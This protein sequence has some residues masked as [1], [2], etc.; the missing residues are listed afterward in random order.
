MPPPRGTAM[1]CLALLAAGLADPPKL[2][3]HGIPLPAG[4]IARLGSSHLGGAARGFDLTPDGKTVVTVGGFWWAD[5]DAVRLWDAATGTLQ[6]SLSHRSAMAVVVSVDGTRAAVQGVGDTSC[7]DVKAG[8]RLWTYPPMPNAG[9][10]TSAVAVSPDGKLVVVG[11]DNLTLLD[12]ATGETV[13]TITRRQRSNIVVAVSF[14]PDGTLVAAEDQYELR[15]WAAATGQ[16]VRTMDGPAT[17]GGLAFTP[18]G[19]HLL[20]AVWD[21]KTAGVPVWEIA[22]GKR[23]RTLAGHAVSAAA[24][25]VSPDGRLAATCGGPSPFTAD[26]S[27]GPDHDTHIYDLATGERRHVLPGLHTAAAGLRFT[28]DSKTLLTGDGAV[29]FWDV[30]TRQQLRRQEGHEETVADLRFDGD[31]L[32]TAGIDGT[33]RGWNP[34]TGEQKWVKP[35]GTTQPVDVSLSPDGRRVCVTWPRGPLVVASEVA[36]GAELGRVVEN[37]YPPPLFTPA[38]DGLLA[39]GAKQ[40]TRHPFGGKPTAVPYPAGLEWPG[41][42]GPDG[43]TA[44]KVVSVATKEQADEYN[45][46]SAIRDGPAP[47]YAVA[48]W[49]LNTGKETGRLPLGE[50]GTRF[51]RPVWSPDGRQIAVSGRVV[52]VW[53]LPT[54]QK[55]AEVLN[56]P[57]LAGPIWSPDGKLLAFTQGEFLMPWDVAASRPAGAKYSLGTARSYK[58]RWSPDGKLLAAVTATTVL[59]YDTP[60]R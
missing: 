13:R 49:D 22:T 6:R 5:G 33:V 20:A 36:T 11:G 18:D 30:A 42:L 19:K 45:K 37:S 59:V 38:G 56:E 43:A 7:W 57:T 2:D 39:I 16:L 1:L 8:R 52:S 50:S 26:R 32:V 55:R 31:T 44:W 23:V 47:P 14:S 34:R 60:V 40:L 17:V 15:V 58:L 10:R 41:G 54:G 24:V 35:T 29:R 48:L 3:R 25:A 4:A 21:N 27:Q 46:R 53:D 9:D 51:A 12:A 28:P